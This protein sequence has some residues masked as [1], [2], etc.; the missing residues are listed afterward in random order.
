MVHR[1]A[2]AVIVAACCLSGN[3]SRAAHAAPPQARLVV[4]PQEHAAA[5]LGFHGHAVGN[6]G[7]VVSRVQF[8]SEAH[9]IGLEP[10]DVIVGVNNYRIRSERDYYRALR[11]SSGVLHLRVL[12]VRGRGVV[13]VRAHVPHDPDHFHILEQGRGR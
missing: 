10:G 7:I 12:D 3:M 8:G 4:P 5:R 2:A 13:S 6:Y 1:F 9:R 11:H